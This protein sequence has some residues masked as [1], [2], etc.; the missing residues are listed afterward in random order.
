MSR[1]I[2][3]GDIVSLHDRLITFIK[4]LDLGVDGNLKK[5]TS[6]IKS[7]LFDSFALFNMAVW[8]E[9]EIDTQVD[10]ATFDLSKEW[11]TIT[12]ILNF[13]QNNRGRNGGQE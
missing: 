7:G 3:Q 1:T 9:Q 5:E 8:I 11:D 13:I 10:L 12:D 6:L 2:T 4:E